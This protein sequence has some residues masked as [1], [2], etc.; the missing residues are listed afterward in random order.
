[1][2]ATAEQ[3]VWRSPPVLLAPMLQAK[4]LRAAQQLLQS[5]GDGVQETPCCR[6]GAFRQTPFLVYSQRTRIGSVAGAHKEAR[7]SDDDDN[8]GLS[9][10]IITSPPSRRLED[11]EPKLFKADAN[12]KRY[13]SFET[14]SNR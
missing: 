3:L 4:Q 8:I 6:L 2:V 7:A 5:R 10:A 12:T 13:E 1:M 9:Q 14:A 11:M